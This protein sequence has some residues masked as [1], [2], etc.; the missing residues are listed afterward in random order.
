MLKKIAL[1][2]L[3]GGERTERVSPQR[4]VA[5]CNEWN[6]TY[7]S[8]VDRQSRGKFACTMYAKHAMLGG[9]GHAPPALPGKF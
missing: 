3:A 8:V 4:Y 5:E 7:G 9:Q 1:K 6:G 2:K